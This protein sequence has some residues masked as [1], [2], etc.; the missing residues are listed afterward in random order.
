MQDNPI[1]SADSVTPQ[2]FCR[3]LR[4]KEMYYQGPIDDE[5]S[6]GIFWCVKTQENAG[7]DGCPC[8]K[9]ECGPSRG[10]YQG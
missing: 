8:G 7:P 5:F 6:S 3:H 1:Q 4:C 9:C 2:C 10:C